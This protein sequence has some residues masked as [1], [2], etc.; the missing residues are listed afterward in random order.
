[1]TTDKQQPTLSSWLRDDC[2]DLIAPYLPYPNGFHSAVQNGC[3]FLTAP[4]GLKPSYAVLNDRIK[5]PSANVYDLKAGTRQG[6]RFGFLFHS[7]L[8][9]L[10]ERDYVVFYR[11][12]FDVRQCVVSGQSAKRK[13]QI[14][15]LLFFVLDDDALLIS[16]AVEDGFSEQLES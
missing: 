4:I 9:M 14:G 1:M 6:V 15:K 10:I 13:Y 5:L 3:L 16:H 8:R 11:K 2:S 7:P 12:Q